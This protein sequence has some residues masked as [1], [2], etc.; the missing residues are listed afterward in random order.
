VIDTPGVRGRC[1]ACS[2][3]TLILGAGGYVTCA[4]L[5]CP[6]PSSASDLLDRPGAADI[7]HTLRNAHVG[8]NEADGIEAA[9]DILTGERPAQRPKRNR[10]TRRKP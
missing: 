10:P 6:N 9:I 3:T 5:D 1:P 8:P 2:R 4:H 7:V